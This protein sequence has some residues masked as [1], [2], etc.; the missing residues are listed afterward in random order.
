MVLVIIAVRVLDSQMGPTL[1]L[2]QTQIPDEPRAGQINR[3]DWAAMCSAI[4]GS[5]ACR[6]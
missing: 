5:L 2:W 3:M 4:A 6:R 1:E